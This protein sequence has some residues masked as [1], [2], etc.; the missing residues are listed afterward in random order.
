MNAAYSIAALNIHKK[1]VAACLHLPHR[2]EARSFSTMTDDLLEMADWL[3]E[4]GVTHV[5]MVSTSAYYKPICNL[6][7]G[8]D[9]ELLL[10]NPR[11]NRPEFAG[12]SKP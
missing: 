10:V 5:A 9:L 2:Q 4:H 3:R 8:Y 1:S 7:E 12:D 11:M 6:L